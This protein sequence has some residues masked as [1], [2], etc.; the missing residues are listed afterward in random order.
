MRTGFFFQLSLI[1]FHI[2]HL[3]KYSIVPKTTCYHF[4]FPFLYFDT[5]YLISLYYAKIP[6]VK[7]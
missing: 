4:G 2:P 7:Q 3:L 6:E 1:F 5:N